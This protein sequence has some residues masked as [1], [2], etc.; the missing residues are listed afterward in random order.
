MGLIGVSA[1]VSHA[2]IGCYCCGQGTKPCRA[3]GAND[4]KGE[5]EQYESGA[6]W[7]L[8]LHIPTAIPE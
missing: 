1:R 8:L 4:C 5:L 7:P 2:R 6:S 3:D